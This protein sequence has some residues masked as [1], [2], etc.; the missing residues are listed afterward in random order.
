MRCIVY[1]CG[2]ILLPVGTD[3]IA[4]DF[5]GKVDGTRSTTRDIEVP[6]SRTLKEPVLLPPPRELP[7]GHGLR[8]GIISDIQGGAVRAIQP[9]TEI[10]PVEL[11]LPPGVRREL[12]SSPASQASPPQH[13]Q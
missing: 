5:L 12:Q 11:P 13:H 2:L 10:R 4:F 9:P 6:A 8:G 1:L 3:A 7:N